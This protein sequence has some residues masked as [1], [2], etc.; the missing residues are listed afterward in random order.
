MQDAIAAIRAACTAREMPFG[1]FVLDPAGVPAALASGVSFLA[2]GTEL[3]LLCAS[4]R[5]VLDT[6]RTAS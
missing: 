4:V 5:S 6:A 3:S 1:L 2:V